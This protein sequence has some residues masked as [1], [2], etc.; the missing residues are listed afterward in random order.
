LLYRIVQTVSARLR[1]IFDLE[2]EQGAVMLCGQKPKSAVRAPPI[3][4]VW[5]LLGLFI[6]APVAGIFAAHESRIFT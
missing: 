4:A 5:F 2:T 6:T 1:V 3:A